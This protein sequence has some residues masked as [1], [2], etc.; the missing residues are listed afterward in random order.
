MPVDSLR[1]GATAALVFVVAGLGFK[2]AA[3][4][5]HQWVPDT[6]EGAPTPVTLSFHCP[7]GSRL[8][9]PGSILLTV[10]GPEVV[11]WTDAML[12]LPC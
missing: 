10:F 5:F 3:V 8:G 11:N 4:P 7:Q 12:F 9:C 6:Y 2:V 1:L